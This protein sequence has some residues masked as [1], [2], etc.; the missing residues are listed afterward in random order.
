MSKCTRCSKDTAHGEGTY[1]SAC[2]EYFQRVNSVRDVIRLKAQKLSRELFPDQ[3]QKYKLMNT[4]GLFLKSNWLSAGGT[5]EQIERIYSL[6]GAAVEP[7][8]SPF[9]IIFGTTVVPNPRSQRGVKRKTNWI[10]GQHDNG[11][12]LENVVEVRVRMYNQSLYGGRCEVKRFTARKAE[13]TGYDVGLFDG[14]ILIHAFD[15]KGVARM[16]RFQFNVATELFTKGVPY[17]LVGKK[18]HYTFDMKHTFVPLSYGIAGVS[19]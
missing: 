2:R 5:T 7:E 9:E 13:A 16:T 19:L 15:A 8:R 1:C 12:S 18:G 11:V 4:H 3:Y 14:G 10:P 6:A 17:T